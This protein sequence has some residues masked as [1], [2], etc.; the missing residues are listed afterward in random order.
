MPHNVFEYSETVPHRCVKFKPQ[1]VP[2]YFLWIEIL[3]HLTTLTVTHQV[4]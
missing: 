2:E 4:Y 1:L 3:S